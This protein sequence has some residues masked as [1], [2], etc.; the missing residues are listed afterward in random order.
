M[1]KSNR[2]KEIFLQTKRERKRIKRRRKKI[3]FK[4]TF[5]VFKKEQHFRISIDRKILSSFKSNLYSYLV[6]QNF[7]TGFEKNSLIIKIPTSFNL[8][9][10]Y[11]ESIETIKDIVFSL[12]KN[13]G[14]EIELDFTRCNNI[15]QSALLLLQIIRLELQNDLSELDKKLII[16]SSQS[17]FK[18]TRSTEQLVNFNLFLCGYLTNVDVRKGLVP[19]DTLG[20]IKGSKSQ[21][22]YFENKKG[23]IGT[24]LVQYIDKCLMNNLY[25]LTA[26]GKNELGNMIGEILNNAEDHS[27]LNTYYVTANYYV[28]EDQNANV[29]VLNLSFMNFGFSIYE[30]FEQ[31]KTENYEVYN[32]LDTYCQKI[33]GTFSKENLF[34]LYALQDGI[35]R[36]K[37]ED[38]SRGTGTMTFINCFYQIGDYENIERALSPQLSILS[39]STHLICNNKYRPKQTNDGSFSLS[40]NNEND[41]SKPPDRN[42]LLPLKYRFPGTILSV[43]FCLN[44]E[45]IQKKIDNNDD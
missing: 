45:H 40:L 32:F 12:W 9:D 21:K 34:T 13:V 6:N 17:K 42:N 27:P 39:G 5:S 28:D 1:K 3:F 35:S 14:K 37:F 7:I 33:G 2:I 22:H 4:G 20:F 30:G 8:S 26:K 43:K 18:I 16:L 23:I 38:Q 29:G 10:N 24:K 15:D 31:T 19:I 11:N 25:S 36:L 41:L 44:T